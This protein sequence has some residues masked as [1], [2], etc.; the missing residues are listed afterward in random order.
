MPE[1][2]F[3]PCTWLE[4]VQALCKL[5]GSDTIEEAECR[6]LADMQLPSHDRVSVCNGIEPAGA[7]GTILASLD[8]LMCKR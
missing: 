4:L 6:L 5:D 2:P 1:D 7:G 8:E 3:L